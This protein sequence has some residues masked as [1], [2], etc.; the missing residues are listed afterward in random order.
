MIILGCTVNTIL[1]YVIQRTF[2]KKKDSEWN[3]IVC[4]S[5]LGILNGKLRK[6]WGG[7]GETNAVMLN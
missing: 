6:V 1:K 7:G 3:R 4:G 2:S 5:V